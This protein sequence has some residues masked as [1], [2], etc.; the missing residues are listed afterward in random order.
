MNRIVIGVNGLGYYF[1]GCVWYEVIEVLI[2]ASRLSPEAV[3]LILSPVPVVGGR[4]AGYMVLMAAAHRT[5]WLRAVVPWLVF[6]GHGCLRLWMTLR[7]KFK[8]I[9]WLLVF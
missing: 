3:L 8:F 6:C 2:G 1:N 7:N 5:Q 9:G 4:T